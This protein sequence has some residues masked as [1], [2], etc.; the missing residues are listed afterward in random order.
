MKIYLLETKNKIVDCEKSAR[1]ILDQADIEVDDRDARKICQEFIILSKCLADRWSLYC[2]YVKWQ[3]E[4]CCNQEPLFWDEKR[5]TLRSAK[6]ALAPGELIN[7]TL[8]TAICLSLRE[9][10]QIQLRGV[11]GDISFHQE[12]E[13]LR[14]CAI[15]AEE[16]M[17]QEALHLIFKCIK[18]HQDTYKDRILELTNEK[19]SQKC[20]QVKLLESLVVNFPR[21]I[22]E[23]NPMQ[24]PEL[25]FQY[26]E[27]YAELVVA[28]LE[29]L[30]VPFILQNSDAPYCYKSME[31]LLRHNPFFKSILHQENESAR[32]IVYNFPEL[33]G[34]RYLNKSTFTFVGAGFPLTGI[35]LH[36]E[37]CASIN[38]ID[39]DENA[40]LTARK[41]L[42]LLEELGIVRQG[43][44]NVIHADAT[45][46]LYLPKNL[47][48][49]KDTL[50]SKV[51]VQTDILDLAS[52][53]PAETTAKVLKEN[54]SKVPLIR[55]RN[56]RG[57][58]EI[59][60]ERFILPKDNDFKLVGEVTPPQSVVNQA[61]PSNLV[62]GLTSPIN[63]N[64]CQLYV[65]T[66]NSDSKLAYLEKMHSLWHLDNNG[67]GNVVLDNKIKQF[68]EG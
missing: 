53:L 13:T 2:Q 5:S 20:L 48:H 3:S 50:S 66:S 45:D 59:W 58:S 1:E 64:S 32:Q 55:K 61:T 12:M 67:I 10:S 34:C 37:T 68:Y 25:P 9:Y 11:F 43:A 46:V 49:E 17:E 51:I 42:S 63:I 26:F 56:V 44:I 18:N 60:Y 41:F 8:S 47:I 39:R 57:M 62:V 28:E 14:Q 4:G 30:R 54:A 31:D 33:F 7:K 22:K 38:L 23:N 35:I 36:I 21:S 52:A 16:A 6:F 24:Y 27:N 29:L 40:V 19:V 65:N 15:H